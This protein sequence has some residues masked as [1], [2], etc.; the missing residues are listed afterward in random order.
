MTKIEDTS[1]RKKKAIYFMVK[2][3]EMSVPNALYEAEKQILL[4]AAKQ[5]DAVMV[6]RCSSEIIRNSTNAKVISIFISSNL[7]DRINR[8]MSQEGKNA[9][10]ILAEIKKKDKERAAYYK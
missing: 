5:G 4:D 2:I 10:T 9:K 1:R 3:G 7:D 8:K 6:G